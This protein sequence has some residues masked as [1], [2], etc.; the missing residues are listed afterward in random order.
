MLEKAKEAVIVR[1]DDD[2]E[3]DAQIGRNKK[4]D[5][6]ESIVIVRESVGFLK[7]VV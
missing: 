1:W 4:T 3:F 2:L 5:E 7:E 6:S